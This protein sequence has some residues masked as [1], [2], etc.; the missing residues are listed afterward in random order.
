MFFGGTC[1]MYS[2]SGKLAKI[3]FENVT[4]K[5]SATIWESLLQLVSE[6]ENKSDPDPVE[7]RLVD[8]IYHFLERLK[9]LEGNIQSYVKDSGDKL[10]G[11]KLASLYENLSYDGSASPFKD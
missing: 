6:L 4:S 9:I 11:N 7:V 10:P 8:S 3:F 2:N 5:Q 1:R